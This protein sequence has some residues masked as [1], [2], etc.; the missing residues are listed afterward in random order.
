[1]NIFRRLKAELHLMV[2]VKRADKAH[3]DTGQRYYIIG[4]DKRKLAIV[5]RKNFRILKRRG[6]LQNSAVNVMDL[7]IE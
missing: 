4:Y 7:E 5:D 2:A 1:M 6:Y 3:E